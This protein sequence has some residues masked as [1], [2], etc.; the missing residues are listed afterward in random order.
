MNCKVKNMYRMETVFLAQPALTP[1]F[2]AALANR[3]SQYSSR[4]Y[5]ERGSTQLS[6]DSLIGLL[7]MNLRSGS[8]ITIAAEGDD[9]QQAAESISLFIRN[10]R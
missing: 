9:A 10:G 4:V 8:K 7:S 1:D 3:A 6:V 5:M 2:A